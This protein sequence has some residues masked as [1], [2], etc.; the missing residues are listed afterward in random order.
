M[1]R[2]SDVFPSAYLRGSDLTGSRDITLGAW[3]IENQYGREEYI[4]DIV[5][6]PAALR[7]GPQ[8]ANE[9]ARSLNE[10]EMDRWPGRTV[11]VYGQG[12]KIKDRTTG[13]EKD[14]IVIH[15]MAS[16]LDKP[17]GNGKALGRSSDVDD[18]IPF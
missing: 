12:R 5:G 16:K 3:R 11:A 14:V 7:C 8:L 15:A 18:D 17:P 6:E 13:E 10:D 9:I 1:P 2:V 4:F